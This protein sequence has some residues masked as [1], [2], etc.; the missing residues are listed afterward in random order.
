MKI[1]DT[2]IGIEEGKMANTWT[3]GVSR[4]S[5]NMKV[6]TTNEF[7]DLSNENRVKRLLESK[8]ILHSA[9]PNYV[10]QTLDELPEII[11]RLGFRIVPKII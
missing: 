2:V 11:T 5:T 7:V 9:K 6:K 4:W 1:D 3:A 10:L 8:K